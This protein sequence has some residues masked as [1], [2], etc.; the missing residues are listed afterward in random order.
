MRNSSSEASSENEDEEPVTREKTEG[1][2]D[3]AEEFGEM[4]D[5]MSGGPLRRVSSF[6]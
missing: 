3:E 5:N 4:G 1:L 2:E 6:R